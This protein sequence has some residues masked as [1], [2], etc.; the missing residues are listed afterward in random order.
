MGFPKCDNSA[1]LCQDALDDENHRQ[2]KKKLLTEVI[3]RL[4]LNI[5][6]LSDLRKSKIVINNPQ[7]DEKRR[8]S[9]QSDNE[10]GTLGSYCTLTDSNHL[11]RR[12]DKRI[13]YEVF[14]KR[15][16]KGTS[17][18]ERNASILRLLI[19]LIL[20]PLYLILSGS[21]SCCNQR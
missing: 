18:D 1:C 14:I 19:V 17:S 3:K 20:S 4:Q 16:E 5:K 15:K 12:L 21:F 10:V 8:F 11:L 13:S 2:E 9:L 6:R 7:T